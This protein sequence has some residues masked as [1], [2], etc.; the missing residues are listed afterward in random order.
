MKNLALKKGFAA[1]TTDELAAAAG[2]SK[3]TLY[4]LFRSKEE[5]IGQLLDEVMQAVDGKTEEIAKSSLPPPEKIKGIARTVAEE[6]GFLGPAVFSDLQRRY[7]R[8]WEK[9]EN[10][11]LGRVDRIRQIY[12]EGC[13]QGSFRK[14]DP[15]V[16]MTAFTAAMRAVITPGFFTSHA[17]SL[18]QALDALMEIFLYGISS[19]PAPKTHNIMARRPTL[20]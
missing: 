16:L 11:R 19:R 20:P 7:P 18:P 1:V 3:R 13:R 8:Q 10:F 5:I 12:L 15:D 6:A 17:V 4:Q 2:V 9:I 14:I